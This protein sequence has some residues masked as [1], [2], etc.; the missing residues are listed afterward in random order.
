MA[1]AGAGAGGLSAD[2]LSEALEKWPL[3][4]FG[5]LLPYLAFGMASMI[6]IL[7]VALAWFHVPLRGPVIELAAVTLI[8][9]IAT[10]GLAMLT[11]NF[12]RSQ[13]AAMLIMISMQLVV[14]ILGCLMDIVAIIMITLPIFMPCVRALGF[15]PVWFG[16]VM[17]INLD[18]AMITTPFGMNL[19]VMREVATPGTTMAD[20]WKAGVPFCLIDLLSMALFIA[21]PPLVLWLPSMMK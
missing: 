12:V 7:I 17:L 5:K 3:P 4:L 20:I 14:V 8:Y 11:V 18:L 1:A 10:F 15:D 2:E 13:Q 16:L 9:F 6:P 19:F 21:F